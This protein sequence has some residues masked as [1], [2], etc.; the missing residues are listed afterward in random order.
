MKVGLLDVFQKIAPDVTGIVRERYLLLRHISD[1]QPVGRRSLATLS[2]LSERVVRA[3]VDV[4]RRNGIVR[5]TTAGIELEA[6][7]QRLMPELLDCFVHLNNLD[8]MQ[9]QIRKELQ[10][11]HVY[12]RVGRKVAGSIDRC[13]YRAGTRGSGES[14]ETSG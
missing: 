12:G 8:D 3:H 7:G 11:E 13:G 1:A 4:L 9:K 10:L 6:E 5:F 2:G 14:C